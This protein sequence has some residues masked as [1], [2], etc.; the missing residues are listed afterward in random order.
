MFHFVLLVFRLFLANKKGFFKASDTV[1]GL[2]T[3]EG[4]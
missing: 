4:L 1:L 3:G 2:P